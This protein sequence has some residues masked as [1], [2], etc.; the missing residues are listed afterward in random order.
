M[1]NYV[2]ERRKA[3]IKRLVVAVDGGAEAGARWKCGRLLHLAKLALDH[4]GGDSPFGYPASA[5]I[6]WHDVGLI[7]L[8]LKRNLRLTAG[9]PWNLVPVLP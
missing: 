1:A 5:L 9:N 8:D 3:E 6:R 7:G 4:M 2:P